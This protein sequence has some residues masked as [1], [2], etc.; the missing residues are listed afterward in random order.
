MRTGE[1]RHFSTR[2]ACIG[3]AV[4]ATVAH[5]SA[6]AAAHGAPNTVP[7]ARQFAPDLRD[8]ADYIP[9][10]PRYGL[11]TPIPEDG[12]IAPIVRLVQDVD[13]AQRG[14][15]AAM[16]ETR[17]TIRRIRH[18][19]FGSVRA[20][21]IREQGIERIKSF[22][23]PAVFGVLIEE[24][25]DQDDDVLLG[26]LDHFASLGEAGQGALAQVAIGHED[27]A[28]RNEATRRLNTQTEAP[29]LFVLDQALRS[30]ND[31]VVNRAAHLVNRLDV[32]E[33]I[34]LLIMQQTHRQPIR[35]ERR[36]RPFIFIGTQRAFVHTLVPNVGGGGGAFAPVIS[37]ISSGV[38]LRVENNHV[39]VYRTAAHDALRAMAARHTHRS[40]SA[41]NELGY[42]RAAWVHWYNEHLLPAVNDQRHADGAVRP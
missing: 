35:Y 33:M 10:D 41:L 17:K 26:L 5:M 24:L 36:D 37:T 20:A 11:L 22:T 6:P 39:L 13:A 2:L 34:P 21:K 23:D 7:K 4:L 30:E 29:V 32:V 8:P 9:E 3:I 1:F 25:N 18:E 27:P 19:H 38:A 42:Q 16:R 15:G 40:A 28:I 14:D 12:N 31:H